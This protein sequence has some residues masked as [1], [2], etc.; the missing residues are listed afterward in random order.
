MM[1]KAEIA[2]RSGY[3]ECNKKLILPQ[4]MPAG[5]LFVKE[6]QKYVGN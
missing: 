2:K 4:C 6:F 3:W 5:D 1:M